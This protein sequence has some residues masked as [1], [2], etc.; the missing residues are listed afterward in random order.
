MT[1]AFWTLILLSLHHLPLIS[2]LLGSVVHLPAAAPYSIRNLSDSTLTQYELD[3]KFRNVSLKHARTHSY[4]HS[5]IQSP[6]Y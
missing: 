3:S 1:A 6:D 4:V 2:P 5:M